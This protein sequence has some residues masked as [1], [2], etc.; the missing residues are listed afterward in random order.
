MRFNYRL[1]VFSILAKWVLCFARKIVL[2]KAKE[3]RKSLTRLRNKNKSNYSID[4]TDADSRRLKIQL[5][6]SST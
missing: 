1:L 4:L 3:L 6:T 5:E 2:L